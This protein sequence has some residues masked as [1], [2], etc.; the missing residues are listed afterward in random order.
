MVRQLDEQILLGVEE[1]SL[2]PVQQSELLG[3]VHAHLLTA[4]V[5]FNL[6]ALAAVAAKSAA[7]RRV[8]ACGSVIE[9]ISNLL[10]GGL[11]L[12]DD[13]T[14]HCPPS[15]CQRADALRGR[16]PGWVRR[17]V[18]L[19]AQRTRWHTEAEL[20]CLW[21]AVE[22]HLITGAIAEFA[23]AELLDVEVP[24]LDALETTTLECLEAMRGARD[25]SWTPTG[26]AL[27]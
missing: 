3:W 23:L 27:P 14:F 6:D 11:P 9:M 15:C 21:E 18:V 17:R 5:A 26:A 16:L 12:E 4:Y 24:D 7:K 13:L 22:A 20:A 1:E 8:L 2:S 25:L 19:A 10:Q